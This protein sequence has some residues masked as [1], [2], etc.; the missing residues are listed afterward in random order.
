MREGKPLAKKQF[1]NRCRA[2][3]HQMELEKKN[4]KP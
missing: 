4:E 1:P 3:P 2:E